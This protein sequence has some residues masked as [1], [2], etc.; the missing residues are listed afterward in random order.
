MSFGRLLVPVGFGIIAAAVASTVLKKMPLLGGA[1]LYVLGWYVSKTYGGKLLPPM[2][3]VTAYIPDFSSMGSRF[4][5]AVPRDGV[6]DITS[7]EV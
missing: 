1:G 6:I 2:V 7:G 5:Q 4:P 3:D